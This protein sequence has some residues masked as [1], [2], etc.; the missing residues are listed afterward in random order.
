[1]KTQV[2]K[3]DSAALELAAGL[4]RSGKLVGIPTETVYGLGANALDPEAVASIFEAKGRPGDNPLIVHIA[5]ISELRPLIA[6]EPSENARKLMEAFWPGPLTLIFPR[7][8]KVPLRTTG[9]LNT[10]AVRMPA[11]PVARE[12]IRMSGLPIAAPSGNRS[13][14]PSPTT[15]AHMFEDM[16]GR[17]D[18]I[19]DGGESD[20]GVE[21]TVVDMTG[22]VPRI[23]R[24]GGVTPEQI[25]AV[26]GG[27]IVDSAVMR[28]LKENEKPRSPGMKYRHYAPAGQL[29]IFRGKPEKVIGEICATYDQALSEGHR[30]L[31]LALE[32]SIPH[33]GNRRLE[34]LGRDAQEMAHAI[35]AALRDADHL[36]ADVIL[37]EGIETEGI[38]L[39]VMNRLGRAAAFH[40]V[41]L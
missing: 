3:P 5:E 40:I 16:D 32:E 19:L 15:A 29:T 30:P 6:A 7:S 4:I 25:E 22:D 8:E 28:P 41:E 26:C 38:G 35:F 39:A 10:V 14:R 17:I 13:G 33:Y 9:G 31:I 21:S 23:L 1:M 27:C 34:S 12:V 20:V 36:H 24:P 2:L 11:H 37:S 18:L